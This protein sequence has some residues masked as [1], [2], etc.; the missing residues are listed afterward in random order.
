MCVGGGGVIGPTP[1]P[2]LPTPAFLALADQPTCPRNIPSTF[3]AVAQVVGRTQR[4][5]WRAG[6][7][8]RGGFV[9]F[10]RITPPAPRTSLPNAP[11]HLSPPPGHPTPGHLFHPSQSVAPPARGG[12]PPSCGR[13]GSPWR[14]RS[15]RSGTTSAAS[16][17]PSSS[18]PWPGPHSPVQF[19]PEGQRA[20]SVAYYITLF[21]G[22]GAPGV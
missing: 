6:R 22:R 12:G 11:R 20:G 4:G 13:A 2:L 9:K 3:G 19:C 17:P 21:P 5:H 8:G 15:R 18:R 14:W 7:C 1:P 10:S 16:P